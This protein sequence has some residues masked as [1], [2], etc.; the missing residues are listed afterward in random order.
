MKCTVSV[1]VVDGSRSPSRS[2][3]KVSAP[4]HRSHALI[5]LVWCLRSHSQAYCWPVAALTTLVCLLT[6]DFQTSL[7]ACWKSGGL[8]EPLQCSRLSS[9]EADYTREVKRSRR[10]CYSFVSHPMW[11]ISFQADMPY[12]TQVQSQQNKSLFFSFRLSLLW[13]RLPP[14]DAGWPRT[15]ASLDQVQ[16]VP[17]AS[18]LLPLCRNTM[19]PVIVMAAA[20]Q[21]TLR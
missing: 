7:L 18:C 16:C 6:P 4:R 11:W 5:L 17:L 19:P 20:T 14:P 15:V 1:T 13:L 9:T 3:T 12:V 10:S 8:A 21:R 2:H